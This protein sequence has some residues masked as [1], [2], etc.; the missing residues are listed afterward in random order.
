M[1]TVALAD[2]EAEA[3]FAAGQGFTV[4]ADGV[5][6][7]TIRA[8]GMIGYGVICG[9]QSPPVTVSDRGQRGSRPPRRSASLI[10][11]L[12]RQGVR[13]GGS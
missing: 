7:H 3:Y 6:D 8:E 9:S 1:V 5:V 10:R 12:S 11:P 13:G 4:W 2:G